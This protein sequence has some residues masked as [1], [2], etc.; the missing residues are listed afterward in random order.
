MRCDIEKSEVGD[1]GFEPG[2]STVGARKEGEAENIRV[3]P[4]KR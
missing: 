4:E 2:T 1:T 3:I